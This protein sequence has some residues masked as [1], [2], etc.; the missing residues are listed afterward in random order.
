MSYRELRNFTELMRAL[1]Y[2]R[3]ISL[4]NFR[5]PNFELVA[6]V[7]YWMV[8]LYEPDTAISD[9]VEFENE[10]VEFLTSIAQLMATKARLKLNTKKLYASDGRAVQELLK[11]ATLLYSAS[12]SSSAS[13][14]NAASSATAPTQPIKLHEVRAA[15][16]LASEIT[17]TGAKVYDL[18]AN[19]A[20]E[21]RER[22]R[23]IRFLDQAASATDGSREQQYI[24]RSIRELIDGTKQAVSDMKKECEELEQDERN[25]DMKIKKKQEELERTEKR[26][27]SLENVR[28]QF[29]DE[30]EKLGKVRECRCVVFAGRYEIPVFFTPFCRPTTGVAKALRHLHG[31]V[32]QLGLF[33]AREREVPTQRGRAARG[34]RA[35]VEED[36]GAAAE[37]GG[38]PVAR[39][40][41]R[42]T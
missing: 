18:L 42:R 36:A 32:P 33:G 16:Q 14:S 6:D 39:W 15:R 26:L 4:E 2:P 31:K 20:T 17:Q 5:K 12:K 11:L 24:E 34:A 13:S 35:A 10:R 41:R 19:E 29:M 1:G 9:R 22:E 23:A 40:P 3:L 21:R 8:K 30:V 27:R 28:P 25:I 7:L 37:R 38:G